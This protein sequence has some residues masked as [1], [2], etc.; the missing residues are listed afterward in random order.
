MPVTVMSAVLTPTM[1]V[2]ALRAMPAVVHHRGGRMVNGRCVINGAR[3]RVVHRRWGHIH[4][5]RCV[6]AITAAIPI[7]VVV[8]AVVA[9]VSDTHHNARHA[10]TDR[11]VDV[12]RLCRA[13]TCH[14]CQGNAGSGDHSVN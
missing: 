12:S 4:R 5:R 13:C 7:A 8:T 10:N 3:R 11:P 9:A 6:R 14:Q 2:V 1:A